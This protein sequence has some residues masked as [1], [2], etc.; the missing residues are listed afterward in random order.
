MTYVQALTYDFDV[1]DK[2][3][4]LLRA[5]DGFNDLAV[6]GR[7][8]TLWTSPVVSTAQSKFGGKSFLMNNGYVDFGTTDLPF[9][10][11][12]FTIE[13]W[14]YT[15]S[16]TGNQWWLSKGDGVS[17]C[18]KTYQGNVY[19]QTRTQYAMASAAAIIPV[20]RWY[21]L[22]LTRK[23]NVYT[24]W[25]DGV[26]KMT[27]TDTAP[28]FGMSAVPLRVGGYEGSSNSYWD[29]IRVSN[30]SRYDTTFVPPASAFELD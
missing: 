26:A 23:G 20:G 10:S 24:I 1:G 30:F 21:H 29:Q 3:R 25:I 15:I 5:T 4:V 27:T 14:V 22:A 2:T 28:G 19:L 13:G 7:K 18:F 12:D 8:L 11:G 6:P 16:I 9:E 17:S